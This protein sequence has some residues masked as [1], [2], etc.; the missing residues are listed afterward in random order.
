MKTNELER[1]MVAMFRRW[2][3]IPLPLVF[4]V[5]AFA[6][7][8][9]P[10]RLLAA[11]ALPHEVKVRNV[12]FV[13]IPEGW[14]YKSGGVATA[15]GPNG[16]NVKVWLDSFYIA[17]YEARARDLVP[18]MNSRL[19]NPKYYAGDIASCS[20]R[21]GKDGNYGLVEP[22]ADLPATHLSWVL[23]DQWARWMGFRLP[24]EAEWEKAARGEDQRTYP[25]GNEPPDDTHANFA[26]T[27]HCL[28]WPVDRAGKGASPYGV[29]NMAGNVREFVA[30]WHNA[31]YDRMQK[32]GLKNPPGPDAGLASPGVKEG[33]KFLKGG[34]W[35]SMPFQL[36]IAERVAAPHDEPFQCNG[37]RFA[38]DVAVVKKHLA[39][40]SA[41][42]LVP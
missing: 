21:L 41:V 36:R 32:D 24:S 38:L 14:F 28:V 39:D 3:L 10:G 5:L 16:G 31:E 8:W 29:V 17:K 20:M 18:F 9:A 42:V 19:P 4:G 37:T 30:D 22:Q 26:V 15:E 40:G 11:E 13:L 12:E 33:S 7:A 23:A 35:A 27:S 6:L 25:W 34:R 2:G 1:I